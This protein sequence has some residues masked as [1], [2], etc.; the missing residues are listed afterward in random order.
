MSLLS[1]IGK[2]LKKAAPLIA[3][4]AQFIPVTAPFATAY[5]IA[6]AARKKDILGVVGGLAGFGGAGG[7]LGKIGSAAKK[8]SSITRAAGIV[9]SVAQRAPG[10]QRQAGM[11]AQPTRRMIQLPPIGSRVTNMSI[12]GAAGGIASR[13]AGGIAGRSLPGVGATAV[14]AGRGLIAGGRGLIQRFPRSAKVLRDLGLFAA[15]GLVYD[16][17]GNLVGQRSPARRINPMNVKAMRRSIRR[18]KAGRKICA[19]IDRMLP[20]RRAAA[21]CAPAFTRRARKR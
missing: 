12:L 19:E 17:A 11:T 18:V 5:N 9:G 15:G 21:A 16:A 1:K 10:Q 6:Q 14:S 13:I 8:V 20:K 7:A 2:T 3:S 4:V